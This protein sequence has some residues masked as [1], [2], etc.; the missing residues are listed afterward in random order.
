MGLRMPDEDEDFTGAGTPG[1][2]GLSRR[3]VI[4][5][6]IIGILGGLSALAIVTS[7][8]AGVW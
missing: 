5:L 3:M 7:A 1:T 2:G 8:E 4:L 6:A